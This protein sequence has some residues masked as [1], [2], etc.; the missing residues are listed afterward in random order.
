MSATASLADQLDLRRPRLVG[1]ETLVEVACT[2]AGKEDAPLPHPDEHAAQ[3]LRLLDDP[4]RRFDAHK[5]GAEAD[6]GR[7]AREA[8]P[9]GRVGEIGRHGRTAGLKHDPRRLREPLRAEIDDVLEL[10]CV[11]IDRMARRAIAHAA[12][13]HDATAAKALGRHVLTTNVVKVIEA[14][15]AK[16]AEEEPRDRG[17]APV[18][19]GF[20]RRQAVIASRQAGARKSREPLGQAI[21][22]SRATEGRGFEPPIRLH[23]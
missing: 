12:R 16:R 18:S 23:G 14:V 11:R 3:G 17:C 2:A 4:K 10:T 22:G 19:G 13:E 15:E 8:D 5:H 7:D 9:I 1:A 21:F 20:Q 6:M